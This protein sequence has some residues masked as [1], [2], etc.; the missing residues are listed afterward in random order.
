[1]SN[2][3]VNEQYHQEE[4]AEKDRKIKLWHDRYDTAE[5]QRLHLSTV[6]IPGMHDESDVLRM[7]RDKLAEMLLE[8]W[9]KHA[10]DDDE[11]PAGAATT[12]EELIRRCKAKNDEPERKP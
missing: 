7:E 10:P 4:L 12:M 1:M 3:E 11:F 2:S 5:K 8:A 9:R 6:I